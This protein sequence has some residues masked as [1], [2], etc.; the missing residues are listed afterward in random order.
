MAIN[1]PLFTGTAEDFKVLDKLCIDIYELDKGNLHRFTVV[2]T[3]FHKCIADVIKSCRLNGC[4]LLP[5]EEMILRDVIK[6]IKMFVNSTSLFTNTSI[7]DIETRG[8]IIFNEDIEMLEFI[9]TSSKHSGEFLEESC[10]QC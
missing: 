3:T 6:C 5:R 10:D 7:Q 8:K 9:L 2:S 1:N 4:T